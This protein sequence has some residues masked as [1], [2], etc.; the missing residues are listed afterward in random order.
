MKY[1]SGTIGSRRRKRKK[2]MAMRGKVE[3]GRKEI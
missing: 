3:K 1:R 2:M